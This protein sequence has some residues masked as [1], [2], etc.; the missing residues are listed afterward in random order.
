MHHFL[1]FG[2]MGIRRLT[3]CIFLLSAGLD[4]TYFLFHAF[5]HFHSPSKTQ[6]K[7][8]TI[9]AKHNIQK[10]IQCSE[11]GENRE[12]PLSNK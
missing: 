10:I 7:E 6:K 3:M 12:P 11:S 9:E 5:S 1:A 2:I 4:Y 8:A